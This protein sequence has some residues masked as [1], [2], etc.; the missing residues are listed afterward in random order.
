MIKAQKWCFEIFLT[1]IVK[2]SA[3]DR[4]LIFSALRLGRVITDI[5]I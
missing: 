4:S 2:N 3:G 1:M 5:Y